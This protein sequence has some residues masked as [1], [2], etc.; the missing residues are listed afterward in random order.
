MYEYSEDE[1]MAE[2]DD[3]VYSASDYSDFDDGEE[4][5]EETPNQRSQP[6][7][8]QTQNTFSAGAG[9]DDDD[10]YGGEGGDFEPVIA[11]HS[12]KKPWEVDFKVFDPNE[13]RAKQEAIISRMEPV[14]A[15]SKD[16]TT[17]LLRAYLWK[18][19]P[20]VED[21]LTDPEGTLTK[22]GISIDQTSPRI[23]S[24]D[25]NFECEICFC[26]GEAEEY[27]A[28]PC[29]HRYCTTCYHTYLVGKV[30]EGASWRITCPTHKCKML[31]GEEGARLL[32][33]DD[34]VNLLRYNSNLTRSFVNDRD[35]F[36]WCPAP[37]CVYA[38]ECHVARSA[39]Y[40]T[41]PSVECKCGNRFCF[42]CQI[43][44]HMPAP[45]YM[46]EKWLQKCRD[47]S[48]TS[49]WMKVNTKE[50]TKCKSTIEKNGGCNH[51]TCRECRYEFCWVCMGS[52]AEHGQHYYNCNRF[53]EESSKEARDSISETRAQLE[54]YIHYFTRY[55]NHEQSAKLARKLL[56]TTEK[57]MEQLQRELTLSW[58]EVQFLNDAVD[59]LSICRSTLKWTYVLAFYMK[60]DNQMIIF[61]NNQSDLESATE[62]LN[63]LV[64]N[65]T[66]HG[67]IEDIKRKIIDKTTY[68]KSRWE[69]L[70]TDTALGLQ[71]SRWQFT[72]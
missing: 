36:V 35:S 16:A 28:A 37:N 68:V 45:C 65:P 49:S 33:K 55:N 57:N 22:S 56:A 15:T 1:F 70:L 29:G 26:D 2:A 31:V 21:F 5:A 34:K 51:M 47:D 46:A 13:L 19:E 14:L 12:S 10:Y 6:V 11:S 69:T 4:S 67:A 30:Q 7:G 39:L 8:T 42:G 52:W 63:D 25:P 17:L 48:E 32:L 9:F 58:I 59:V 53:N 43:A 61:E 38:I 24:G 72:I 18:D 71:E 20:L 62:Q 41:V 23:M 3:F 64:E 40:T 60:A 54:R 66:S 44:D 27:F 50:C